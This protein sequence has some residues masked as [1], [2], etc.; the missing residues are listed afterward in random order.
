VAVIYNRPNVQTYQFAYPI[1]L[2]F[3]FVV[4]SVEPLSL[5]RPALWCAAGLTMLGA[6]IVLLGG[7]T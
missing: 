2:Y 6:E 1:G 3:V 7:C 4:G 5:G